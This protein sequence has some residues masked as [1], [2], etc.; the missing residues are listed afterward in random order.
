MADLLAWLWWHP[1]GVDLSDCQWALLL[2][3]SAIFALVG[4][5]VLAGAQIAALLRRLRHAHQ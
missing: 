5:L 4:M 2:S 3:L 1:T